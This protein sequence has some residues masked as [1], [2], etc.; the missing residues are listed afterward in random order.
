ML[1]FCTSIINSPVRQVGE[2]VDVIWL[3]VDNT[4]RWV[5]RTAGTDQTK[6]VVSY[7][8]L[9]KVGSKVSRLDL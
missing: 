3:E 9:R 1:S 2:V 8:Y 5:W 6:V 4:L 7:S